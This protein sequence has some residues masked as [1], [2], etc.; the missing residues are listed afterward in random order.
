MKNSSKKS[1][2]ADILDVSTKLFIE[3][4]FNGTTINDIADALGVTRTNIYYY[5]KDKKEILE[6]LTGDVFLIGQRISKKA[7]TSTSDPVAALRELVEILVRVVLTNPQRYR[8]I[9]RNEGYLAP[10]VRT[11]AAAVK[12]TVF[13]DFRNV[14]KKGIQAGVFRA[15]DPGIAAL[16]IIGMCSWAAWWFRPDDS[17]SIDQAVE[18]LIDLALSTIVAGESKNSP[19]LDALDVIRNLRSELDYLEKTLPQS[20]RGAGFRQ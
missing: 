10:S 14:I 12:K 19:R 3:H 2:R 5:F 18:S 1:L 17:R 9:E 4:G 6:E 13:A 20:N 15:V 16:A 8:V 7:S 11:K